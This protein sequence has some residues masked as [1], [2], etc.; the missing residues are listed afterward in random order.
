M[1][2][3]GG[4]SPAPVPIPPPPAIGLPYTLGPGA[5]WA[6]THGSLP[7]G[8]T[9]GS[10]DFQQCAS[11]QTCWDSYV[12]VLWSANI[13]FAKN[14]VFDYE[15]TGNDPTFI[16]DS[17]NNTCPGFPSLSLLIHR[18]ND[19]ALMVPTYRQFSFPVQQELKLG[20]ITYTVPIDQA[21]FINVSGSGF[22]DTLS[23]VGSV[24]F[25]L[26]GRCF[27]GHGVAVSSGN[28]KLSIISYTI[29]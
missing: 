11:A 5:Q 13:A 21:N 7:R 15:I 10:F 26:G 23:N 24:G 4:K 25:V 9:N 6:I 27:A 8:L 2:G 20:R 18:S 17:P 12:E 29:N 28:A 14:I 19:A 3:C 1:T 16:N 22:G